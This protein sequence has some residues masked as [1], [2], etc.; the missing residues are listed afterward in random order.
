MKQS[1]RSKRWM[2]DALMKLLSQKAYAEI[3][4]TDIAE[5][6]GVSRL[7]FYRNFETKDAILE[8]HLDNIFNEYVKTLPD[9]NLNLEDALIQCFT[10]WKRYS[11]D[12]YILK[13]N[14][15]FPLMYAP[16]KKNILTFADWT[17]LKNRYDDYELNFIMGG[18]FS[19]MLAYV[20]QPVAP[21]KISRSIIQLLN[22]R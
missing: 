2:E 21:E 13:E 11:K 7:T 17:N 8:Y 1:E 3:T 12:I 5:K 10:Y 4:V 15:L 6:A 9:V 19:S 14:G 20:D 18:L 22:L 16:F